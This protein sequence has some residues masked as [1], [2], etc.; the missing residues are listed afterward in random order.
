MDVQYLSLTFLHSE[1]VG[2]MSQG[3]TV[4]TSGLDTGSQDMA[5][6]QERCQLIA[7]YAMATLTAMAGSAGHAGLAS[8]L[9]G[10]SGKSRRWY[11]GA[12]A[13][14]G[15]ASQSLS[16]SSKT[17]SGADQ[18]VANQVSSVGRDGL[19]GKLHG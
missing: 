2:R 11:T 6:L 18:G 10:A 1:Q 5:G 9:N 15:H 19:F 13:A 17:Y 14:Y 12:W 3:F 4:K 8:A 7:E 16:A